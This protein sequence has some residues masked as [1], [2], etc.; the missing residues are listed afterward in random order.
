MSLPAVAIIS[1]VY[2]F[3]GPFS[4][5]DK[6]IPCV[7]ARSILRRSYDGESVPADVLSRTLCVQLAPQKEPGLSF[8]TYPASANEHYLNASRTFLRDLCGFGMYLS[9]L[10]RSGEAIMIIG[11]DSTLPSAILESLLEARTPLLS[12][13]L[14]GSERADMAVLVPDFHFIDSKGFHELDKTFQ[15]SSVPFSE[16]SPEVFWRGS[17][18][19][20]PCAYR[21]ESIEDKGVLEDCDRGCFGLQRVQTALRAK[22]SPWLNVSLVNAVQDCNTF[23]GRQFLK[24]LGLSSTGIEAS[25][26]HL[27]RGILELDGNVNA[28][29]NRWRMASGSV[30]FRV[31]SSYVNSY[32]RCQRPWEHYIPIHSNLSN[33][34]EATSI[35][36]STDAQT[37]S[38]LEQIARRSRAL[39]RGFTYESELKRVAVTLNRVWSE[40]ER[41]AIEAIKEISRISCELS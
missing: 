30:V 4:L 19:G 12:H 40:S 14:N 29:G 3:L 17:T 6:P 25:R 18:T 11:D 32:I 7:R 20:V 1:F 15:E 24:H 8:L 38:T 37:L 26:W 31:E 2:L 35:V 36:R 33:L 39:A 27:H 41:M 23:D 16:R 21:W 13:A 28:W 10:Q 22:R 9:S 34:E 5:A